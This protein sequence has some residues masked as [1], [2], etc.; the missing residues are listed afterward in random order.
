MNLNVQTYSSL[1][2]L[3]IQEIAIGTRLFIRVG[4]GKWTQKR[5]SASPTT[6]T[7]YVG[8][9]IIGTMLYGTLALPRAAARSTY[10]SVRR[11]AT[12]SSSCT[13]APPAS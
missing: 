6:P 10:G 9:E 3:K 5:E 12:L 1:G 13:A 2:V 4:K 7:V 8:Q 11:M